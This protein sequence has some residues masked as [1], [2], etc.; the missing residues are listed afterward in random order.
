MENLELKGKQIQNHTAY[1]IEDEYQSLL[2][3]YRR[4]Y[5]HRIIDIIQEQIRG[6]PEH[7]IEEWIEE[8]LIG[9]LKMTGA[10][11]NNQIASSLYTNF[12]TMIRN[13]NQ[14]L[15]MR[16]SKYI[17]NLNEIGRK[18]HNDSIEDITQDFINIVIRRIEQ[19]YD[20]FYGISD[21]NFENALENI[22]YE[23]RP[24]IRRVSEEF[25]EEY[26]SMI[27]VALKNNQNKMEGWV[28]ESKEKNT[29]IPEECLEQAERML[30]YHD[31][32]LLRKENGLYIRN[33][34][35]N[36]V[37]EFTYNP[38]FKLFNSQS[39]LGIQIINGSMVGL[40]IDKD[41]VLVDNQTS[42]EIS[43]MDRLAII[44]VC[45]SQR[46]YDFYLDN[47]KIVDQE[48]INKIIQFIKIKCPGYY[49]KLLKDPDFAQLIQTQTNEISEEKTNIINEPTETTL[50]EYLELEKT[51]SKKR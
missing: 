37:Y 7:R 19:Y 17:E 51:S 2:I 13:S 36:Q 22:K 9:E 8:Y 16:Y 33:K 29:S 40:N 24:N 14:S 18:S 25:Q 23:L 1:E 21:R 6:I 45:P 48:K 12:E 30:E 32:E 39:G 35:N 28:L 43:D 26:Q 27:K 42:L 11:Q 41:L 34:D 5:M 38:E 49:N 44:K 3:E 4:K 46:G 20:C 15:D 47:K 50:S 10:R 31:F